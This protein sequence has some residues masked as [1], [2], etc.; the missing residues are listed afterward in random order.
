MPAGFIVK[1][2]SVYVDSLEKKF[3][4]SI[5][6]AVSQNNGKKLING[7]IVTYVGLVID[8]VIKLS[9]DNKM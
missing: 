1:V 6:K 9:C 4:G 3:G 7:S 2:R 8:Y 5:K